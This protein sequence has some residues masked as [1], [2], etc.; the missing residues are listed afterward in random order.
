MD[1]DSSGARA[2]PAFGPEL[3]WT[4]RYTAAICCA[5][6]SVPAVRPLADALSR[7]G[8]NTRLLTHESPALALAHRN[9]AL[10][11]PTIY[12]ACIE[13]RVSP[14]SVEP[15]QQILSQG[16]HLNEHLFVGG[17]DPQAPTA[18]VASIVRFAESLEQ[19]DE[20]EVP[21]STTAQYFP[22]EPPEHD[23]ADELPT[24]VR[25]V[26]SLVFR[27]TQNP[28]A[29]EDAAAIPGLDTEALSEFEY[30]VPI[31]E[32]IPDP[33]DHEGFESQP[34]QSIALTVDD[35][36]PVER[37]SSVPPVT[38]DPREFSTRHFEPETHADLPPSS[39]PPQGRTLFYYEAPALGEG[40]PAQPTGPQDE[41]GRERGTARYRTVGDA[42]TTKSVSEP[43]P[44]SAETLRGPSPLPSKRNGTSW[45]VALGSASAVVGFALFV[46]FTQRGT[47]HD[48]PVVVASAAREPAAI[49][50]ERPEVSAA[51]HHRPEDTA[52]QIVEP[53]SGSP[54]SAPTALNPAESLELAAAAPLEVREL[55]DDQMQAKSDRDPAPDRDP[56][57]ETP[58]SAGG[59]VLRAMDGS[60]LPEAFSRA[61]RVRDIVPTERLYVTRPET[62]GSRISWAQALRQCHDERRGG[63][64]GWRLPHRRELKL[65]AA[66]GIL[67]E[68]TYWSRTRDTTDRRWIYVMDADERNL[69]ITA[70]EE[71]AARAVCVYPRP[72][73]Q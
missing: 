57:S 69:R 40:T 12:I 5:E 62:S 60:P 18:L 11:G 59:E 54:T 37:E 50:H 72:K 64:S 22:T 13:E 31:D 33:E 66:I 73:E 43:P 6:R 4:H 17:F 3:S 58:S 35:M 56:E 71:T 39:A 53:S 30:D 15:L 9:L 21:A 16:R 44:S 63:V 47:Q 70:M 23:D 61:V 14:D 45:L 52:A 38:E 55:E 51:A 7:L 36:R 49:P 24:D 10:L 67:Q 42:I 2:E 32:N 34:T 8:F 20:G 28:L 26:P 1:D 29:L 25:L 65:L 48:A 19:L 27:S 68:G 46:Y 41:P